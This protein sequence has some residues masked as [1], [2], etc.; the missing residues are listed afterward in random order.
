MFRRVQVL[1]CY[2]VCLLSCRC[3]YYGRDI[4]LVLLLMLLMPLSLIMCL[5]S[6]IFVLKCSGSWILL[7]ER[8][9]GQPDRRVLDSG[10]VASS[11]KMRG[12][13]ASRS[14]LPIH[15]SAEEDERKDSSQSIRN[16]ECDSGHIRSVCHWLLR[17]RSQ[18][19]A[20]MWM[21]EVW[22]ER[23]IECFPFYRESIVFGVVI[24]SSSQLWR[25]MTSYRLRGRRFFL[26]WCLHPLATSHNIKYLPLHGPS[27]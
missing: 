7:L 14:K 17:E 21:F 1:S 4:L 24:S 18:I 6:I 8:G 23:E 3:C 15:L 13:I 12:I 25:G 20:K 10:T 11:Q 22:S 27:L 19:E 26:P 2:H 9:F 16:Q 5:V